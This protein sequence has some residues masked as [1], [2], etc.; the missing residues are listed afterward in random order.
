MAPHSYMLN[1]P[2]GYTF[3]PYTP[4][5]PQYHIPGQEYNFSN[6][7]LSGPNEEHGSSGTFRQHLMSTG[8]PSIISEPV[9]PD[10]KVVSLKIENLT[11]P[12]FNEA[13]NAQPFLS[14]G[15]PP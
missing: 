5:V 2:S 6:Q 12:G 14:N 7:G 15:Y 11:N 1:P 9:S 8:H 3:A 4:F 10:T 13:A